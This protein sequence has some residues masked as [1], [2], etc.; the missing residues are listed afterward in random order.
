MRGEAEVR[1]RLSII[2]VA[3]GRSEA[4]LALSIAR[5]W[6]IGPLRRWVAPT[7][8]RPAAV[9]SFLESVKVSLLL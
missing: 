7:R 8:R 9:H 6:K 4:I 2:V 1:V 3:V 5:Y